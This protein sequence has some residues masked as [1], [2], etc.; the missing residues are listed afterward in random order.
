MFHAEIQKK[1]LIIYDAMKAMRKLSVEIK[2]EMKRVNI[3]I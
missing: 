3:K 2:D 1:A